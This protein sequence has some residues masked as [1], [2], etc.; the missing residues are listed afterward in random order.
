MKVLKKVGGKCSK[1]SNVESEIK[2]VL[3]LDLQVDGISGE[4]NNMH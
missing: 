4:M 2:Q 3:I 1:L